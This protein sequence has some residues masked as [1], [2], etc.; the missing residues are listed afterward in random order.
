MTALRRPWPQPLLAAAALFLGGGGVVAL[1]AVYSADEIRHDPIG[2]ALLAI[3]LGAITVLTQSITIHV[4]ENT[5]TQVSSLLTYLTV[6]LL[7]IPLA[8]TTVLISVMAADFSV[9]KQRGTYLSDILTQAG[10]MTAVAAAAA[11]VAH[12]GLPDRTARAAGIVAAAGILWAGDVLTLPAIVYPI[13][14]EKPWHIIRSFV[15][16]AGGLEAALY[17]VGILG[18]E[19]A[20]Q[21]LWSVALLALPVAMVYRAGKRTKEMQ[22]STRT[23]L[24]SLADTVDLRDPY[25]GGH[26]LRVTEYTRGILRELA[27]QGPDVDLIITAARVH[28][29]GKIGIPD[30]VLLKDGQLTEEERAIMNTHPEKGADLLRRHADFGR[31]AQIVLHHHE[32]WNGSG[33]PHRLRGAE[34]PFGARVI[35]VADA[36]DAMTSN[37]PYRRGMLVE[38]AAGILRAGR[39]V[40]WDGA[41]VD[42]FLRSIADRLPA[43]GGLHLRV[44]GAKVEPPRAQ[45]AASA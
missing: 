29:I 4:R 9:R 6:V 5:K 3:I 23:L 35:A 28:D 31:G 14:G 39:G 33:Y 36:F 30:A 40:Q 25:T 44:V 38:K 26:S 41:V 18:A 7:P 37:R 45:D 20:Q 10:R 34:I 19:A 11:I 24:E 12:I 21:A 22:D 15:R 2:N 17:L 16:E 8:A 1:W 43:D 42:A 32:A 13:T 27:L